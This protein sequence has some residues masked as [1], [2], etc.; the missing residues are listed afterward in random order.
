MIRLRPERGGAL[1]MA[2]IVLV[3]VECIVAG[4]LHIAMVERRVAVNTD[5]AL[6][7]RLAAG[8]A[9]HAAV[10]A[11]PAALDSLA[12]GDT[13]TA[14]VSSP[15]E[16]VGVTARIERLP[17]SLFL[18]R[19]TA[20]LPPPHP[21]RGRATLLVL[22]PALRRDADLVGAALTA[23]SAEIDA[24]ATV[25]AAEQ[26]C[27]TAS[28]P[29]VRI[30]GATDPVLWPAAA[31]GGSVVADP[32]TG[33]PAHDMPRVVSAVAAS[34][35][36]AWRATPEEPDSGAG[37]VAD[38]VPLTGAGGRLHFAAGDLRLQTRVAG[39][40]VVAGN[41]VLEPGAGISG[42]LLAG[43]GLVLHEGASLTGAAHVAGNAVVR[44]AVR[45]DACQA[46]E[47]ARA[48]GLY[49]PHPYPGRAAPP[50]F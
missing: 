28:A 35:D 41:V 40:L 23:G 32:A 14:P 18:V 12:A 2:I 43:A 44:G 7:L 31:V 4:T 17:G 9:A 13:F 16:G 29:A 39:V 10:A 5:V 11:W 24:T 47:A 22:P 8:T 42:L 50:P 30:T 27:A 25:D 45:F 15:A 19:A 26:E 48:A 20:T 49:R 38:P 33:S 46:L 36:G 21:G 34:V 3:I 6:R 1:V 37:S